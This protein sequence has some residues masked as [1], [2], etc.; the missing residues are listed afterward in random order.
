[1]KVYKIILIAGLLIAIVVGGIIIGPVILMIVAIQYSGFIISNTSDEV[2]EEEFAKI[3]EVEFFIHKYP[4]YTTSHLQDIIG[5]K[6][7]F[8]KF[9]GENNKSI[10]LEVKKSVLN[11]SVKISA[12]CNKG[13]F[14]AFD[15]PQDRVMDYLQDNECLGKSKLATK[16]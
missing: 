15:I 8:Y 5:W 12:G 7:I 11:Q 3:P 9:K 13:G 4:N 14:F 10:N 6:I 16:F 1:M 2:F